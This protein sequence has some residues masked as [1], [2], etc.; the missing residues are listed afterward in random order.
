MYGSEH[1][2]LCFLVCFSDGEVL[3]R[4]D[5]P[6]LSA[7]HGVDH[8]LSVSLASPSTL[9]GETF[10]LYLVRVAGVAR[11]QMCWRS[12][13]SNALPDVVTYLLISAWEL[14]WIF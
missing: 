1:V 3:L 7:R 14:C 2:T 10:A 12:V 8:A 9:L 5:R 13:T 11:W 4:I 6:A